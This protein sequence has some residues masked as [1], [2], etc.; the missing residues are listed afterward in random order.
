MNVGF[1]DDYRVEAARRIA[2]RGPRQRGRLLAALDLSPDDLDAVLAVDV[3]LDDDLDNDF[4]DG[5]WLPLEIDI[6][7]SA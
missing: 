2:R 7:V 3:P 6:G 4:G 1:D 5:G